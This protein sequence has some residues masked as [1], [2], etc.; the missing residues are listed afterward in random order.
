[1]RNSLNKP[2]PPDPL[3][4]IIISETRAVQGKQKKDA[5][6]TPQTPPSLDS[7][8]PLPLATNHQPHSSLDSVTHMPPIRPSPFV[9]PNEK[10]FTPPKSP[11]SP[12]NSKQPTDAFAHTRKPSRQESC[13]ALT[14]TQSSRSVVFNSHRPSPS[15]SQRSWLDNPTPAPSQ[16]PSRE[17]MGQETA[18]DPAIPDLPPV[19]TS[20]NHITPKQRAAPEYIEQD[21]P[22]SPRFDG[23]ECDSNIVESSVR[24]SQLGWPGSDTQPRHSP[25]SP[26]AIAADSE[27]SISSTKSRAHESMEVHSSPVKSHGTGLQ[28]P[29]D[30]DII[31]PV[32]SPKP[33]PTPTLPHPKIQSISSQ[34]ALSPKQRSPSQTQSLADVPQSSKS[35]DMTALPKIIASSSPQQPLN[36]RHS[37][38][39]PSI[40]ALRSLLGK[41]P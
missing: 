6:T 2:L 33:K 20:P 37:R 16:R 35:N 21:T 25:R 34:P 38:K 32:V 22:V 17:Q 23:Q 4:P 10:F 5:F 26:N 7:P 14:R 18:A 13:P 19:P 30:E 31:E 39:K 41:K 11:T 28:I 40:T 27:H 15:E 12:P 36:N 3:R 29:I 24:A 1:M 9:D 8:Y